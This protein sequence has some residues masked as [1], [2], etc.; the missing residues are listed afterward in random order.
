VFGKFPLKI[1]NFSIA[2]PS[3]KKKIFSGWGKKH[4]GQRRVGLL[5][6]EGQKY[7]LVESGPISTNR[8]KVLIIFLVSEPPNPEAEGEGN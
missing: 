7:A 5:F 3:G 2:L 1:S 4:P 8:I 6:T